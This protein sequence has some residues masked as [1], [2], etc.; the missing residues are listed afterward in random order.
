[1]Q[2]LCP[3][4]NRG[5]QVED[6]D[7]T[8]KIFEMSFA[9]VYPLLGDK[10]EKMGRTKAQLDEITF[11]LTGEDAHGLSTALNDGRT[12]ENILRG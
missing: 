5:G 3:L 12:F 10:V 1:M 7:M 8:S 4:K 11:W 6:G 2:G 9:N